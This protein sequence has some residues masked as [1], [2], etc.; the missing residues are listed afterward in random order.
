MNLME[1]SSTEP[2]NQMNYYIKIVW[3]YFDSNKVINF[4][5]GFNTN[6]IAKKFLEYFEQERKNH[7]L[8]INENYPC[9]KYYV[10]LDNIQPRPLNYIHS[11]L[12]F[13]SLENS[14]LDYMNKFSNGENNDPKQFILNCSNEYMYV[15]FSSYNEIDETEPMLV[16]INV[17]HKLENIDHSITHMEDFYNFCTLENDEYEK[18][19]AKSFNLMDTILNKKTL[20]MVVYFINEYIDTDIDI[21]LYLTRTQLTLLAKKIYGWIEIIHTYSRKT[22]FE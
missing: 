13:E 15:K 1:I 14:I 12:Q 11:Q 6:D 17:R 21:I 5:I 3:D 9:E 19:L 20:I 2:I 10:E 22:K 7:L 18:L 8:F 16:K 4:I